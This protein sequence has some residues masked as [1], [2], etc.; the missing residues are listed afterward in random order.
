MFLNNDIL[1]DF[2][3]YGILFNIVFFATS[4]IILS[5]LGAIETIHYIKKNSFVNYTEILAS[6]LAP[7]ISIIAPAYNESLTIVENIRSLLSLHYVNYEVLIINDGSTDDSLKK[8]IKTYSLTKVNYVIDKK[9][10]TK[11]VKG[12]YKS[13]KPSFNKLLVIDKENGG[14]ADALNLGLNISK[15]DLVA[16]IDADCIMEPDALLKMVKPFLE[17]EEEKLIA[18]GGVVRVANSCVIKDGKL[19]EVKIPEKFLAK[20][21][22]LEYMRSFL[23]G[24]MA[25]SRLNGL[26]IVSGAFGLFDRNILIAS[27]GYNKIIGEDLEL[28]V[29]IRKYMQDTG[30]KYKVVYIPDPL[31]WTEVPEN[32]KTLGSQRNRWTRGMIETLLIHKKL[33]FNSSYGIL[34]IISYPYLF[35]YEWLAPIIEFLG[36]LFFI[37]LI[38][39]GLINWE[40]FLISLLALYTFAIMY[41]MFS[42]L[43]EELT[44][45]QYVNKRALFKLIL[46][47]L[48]EPIFFHPYIMWSAI[49][50]N[51]DFIFSRNKG[52]GKMTRTGFISKKT[53]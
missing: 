34:G 29:R 15:N 21:Q 6:S 36:I 3:N 19:I 44:Y 26:L 42:I 32:Y 43:S 38:S 17:S 39:F 31:C 14:K 35:F 12:V 7:S 41:S 13:T 22:V 16:S 51:F 2:F 30:K 47:A 23:L 18:A 37:F 27:G 20:Y 28:V 25:W 8:I 48:L 1:L 45:R 50:G 52:W 53:I 40:L 5:V 49:K 11:G 10:P 33:F 9:L 24:R 46:I 4:Y